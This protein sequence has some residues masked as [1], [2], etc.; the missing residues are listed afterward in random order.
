MS[1]PV[2]SF[3]GRIASSCA[4]SLLAYPLDMSRRSLC[5]ALHFIPQNQIFKDAHHG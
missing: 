4:R 5:D 3:C 2:N 1:I